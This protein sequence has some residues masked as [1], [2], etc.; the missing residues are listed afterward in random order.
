MQHSLPTIARFLVL[1]TGALAATAAAFLPNA[2]EAEPRATG[3]VLD[4]Y[5]D[6][7]AGDGTLRIRE[8]VQG[9][10][11]GA[12]FWWKSMAN[13]EEIE[14]VSVVS[15][16]G[17]GT[18][19]AVEVEERHVRYESADGTM[20][21]EMV[22]RP[23]GIG[24]HG[25]QGLVT[26][27]WAAFDGR[28]LW[29]PQNIQSYSDVRWH[30]QM[31]D[32]WKVA[33]AMEQTADGA[34]HLSPTL[35][36]Q[37]RA[38]TTQ[39]A[40]IGLGPFTATHTQLGN[41]DLR[42]WT[43][44]GWDD[45]ADIAEKTTAMGSW[46]HGRLG[47]DPGRPFSV[48]W[49]PPGPEMAAVWSG[50]GSSGTCY[51]RPQGGMKN[52]LLLGHRF[53]HPLNEYAPDGIYMARPEDQWFMEG[54]A[55]Y[56]EVLALSGAGLQEEQI[57]WNGLY[58]IYNRNRKAHPE[59][60]NTA[61]ADE[62]LV[63]DADQREH[64][65][66]MHAPLVVRM[67]AEFVKVRS[68]KNLE[69]F[70]AEMFRTH[71]GFTKP[72]DLRNELET[73]SG[74]PLDDFWEAMVDQPG[75]VPPIWPEFSKKLDEE[76]HGMVSAGSSA[77]SETQIV[78]LL[79]SATETHAGGVKDKLERTAQAHEELTRRKI[80]LVPPAL[81]T[82]RLTLPGPARENLDTLTRMWPTDKGP[83]LPTGGCNKAPKPVPLPPL[84]GGGS[85][86]E[87]FLYLASLDT[88]PAMERGNR[89]VE[90]FTISARE[91]PLPAPISES[92]VAKDKPFKVSMSWAAPPA[93][94]QVEIWHN[95]KLVVS[96]PMGSEIGWSNGWVR[97]HPEQLGDATGVLRIRASD[98]GGQLL[99]Q[100]HVWRR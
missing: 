94:V 97:F 39:S 57:H 82:R 56:I 4:I 98:R 40:C 61:L 12:G 53:A 65:H 13:P 7:T 1:A 2:G 69:D 68:G 15:K 21:L 3:P 71:G 25:H 76:A 54:W 86:G 81:L 64:L 19:R 67:L 38:A 11:P 79:A 16:D 33:S 74:A 26:N 78:H 87:A 41:T 47:F 89:A 34:W 60:I 44:D 70:M 29:Y 95:K 59:W 18:P 58:G 48:V 92:V 84:R 17:S 45:A 10:R 20:S 35:T 23:G 42:V 24:R 31:P 72:L 85:A 27:E 80:H 77:W 73:W 43:Y 100:R 63:Q 51:E 75:P 22:V 62:P 99:A 50:A 91:T 14:T 52:W 96:R 30:F 28:V 90:S 37:M 49:T 36:P 32:G 88:D 66:Y 9:L 55:S 83:Q 6:A 93:A 5:V 8:Q 46:F